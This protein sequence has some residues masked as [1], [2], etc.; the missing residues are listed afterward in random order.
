MVGLFTHNL[1]NGAT[2]SLLY[3]FVDCLHLKQRNN[4]N[5]H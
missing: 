5:P 4:I 1:T 3:C 2:Q